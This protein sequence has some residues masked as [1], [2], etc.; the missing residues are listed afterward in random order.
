M[1]TIDARNSIA[2][3]PRWARYT[4][5]H[6]WRS[7]AEEFDACKLG[8]WL[9]LST[10]V[11]LFGGIFCAYVIFRTLYPAAWHEGSAALDWRWGGLNTIILLVSSY[12]MAASIYCIQ[13]AQ[14]KRAQLNLIIT[15]ICGALFVLIK[16]GFE[17]IPKWSGYF[18]FFDPALSHHTDSGQTALGGL[19]HFVEAYGGK[20]PGSLFAYPFA[21]SPQ[22]PMW[23]SVYYCGTAIHALHV[24]IGMV[25]I[26]RVLYRTTKGCY[27]PTHYTMVEVT[28]LYWHLVDL[29]WIFLFPLLYLIH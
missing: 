16:M 13:T 18:L 5:A 7:A 20:R 15:L 1:T 19:F 6:H 8:F 11:L 26:A 23:W 27:G 12:T 4:P 25:L 2:D 17:Y 3:K 9:F 21:V 14:F 22:M 29:I 24:I 10:E 28:G